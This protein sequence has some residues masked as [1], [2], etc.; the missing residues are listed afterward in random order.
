MTLTVYNGCRWGIGLR[1]FVGGGG[2]LTEAF[3][4]HLEDGRVMN[5]PV[6]SRDGHGFVGEDLIPAA[7]GLIG[8]DG[9]AAVFVASSDQFE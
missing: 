9:D 6:D 1:P 5:E 3:G 8:C 7:K 2:T 4:V